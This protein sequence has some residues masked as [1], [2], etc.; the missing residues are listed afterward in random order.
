MKRSII[1][2]EQALMDKLKAKTDSYAIENKDG[3]K[4]GIPVCIMYSVS[5]LFFMLG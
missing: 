3:F 4:A 1:G 2:D 5:V